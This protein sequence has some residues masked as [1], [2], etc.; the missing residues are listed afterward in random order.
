M[1]TARDQKE[2][3]LFLDDERKPP[4]P[5]DVFGWDVVHARNIREFI[6]AIETRGAPAMVCFDWY[7]GPGQPDGL[8][9]ARWMT[10][11]DQHSGNIIREDMIFDSQSSDR[12]KAREI[13]RL[14]ADYIARKFSKDDADAVLRASRRKRPPRVTRN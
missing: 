6:E 10:F 5:K 13:E 4:E 3:V 8:E 12:T 2:Y 11:E 7:L 14:I 1:E 9:A